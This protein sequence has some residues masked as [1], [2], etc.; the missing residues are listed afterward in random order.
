MQKVIF[1]ISCSLLR[2]I[3]SIAIIALSY[4]CRVNNKMQ[5]R[6]TCTGLFDRDGSQSG[7][8]FRLVAGARGKQRPASTI[9]TDV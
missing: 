3:V 1:D 9:E 7:I 2:S 5:H 6:E 4:S 8:C